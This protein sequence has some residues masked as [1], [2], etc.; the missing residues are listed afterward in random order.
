MKR[1]L[2][3]LAWWTADDWYT[4]S[5]SVSQLEDC[6]NRDKDCSWVRGD[7]YLTKC[8][9][10]RSGLR[11]LGFATDVQYNTIQYNTSLIKADRKQ[12]VHNVKR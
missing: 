10:S 2:Q 7:V 4:G 3:L 9:F 1:L 11:C 12:L 8:F 6:Q 5:Y